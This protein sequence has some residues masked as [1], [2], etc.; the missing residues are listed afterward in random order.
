MVSQRKRKR[1]DT[2]KAKKKQTKKTKKQAPHKKKQVSRKKK[3]ASRKKTSNKVVESAAA[4]EANPE[5][6]SQVKKLILLLGFSCR[7]LEGVGFP[8]DF[9][10]CTS[11]ELRVK[12]LQ[13]M[14]H[15]DT[16]A[17]TINKKDNYP[18]N[19]YHFAANFNTPRFVDRLKTKL[20]QQFP[21]GVE[22]TDV[23]L[24]YY[25]LRPSWYRES[26]GT[27]WPTVLSALPFTGKAYLPVS[28]LQPEE[29]YSGVIRASPGRLITELDTVPLCKAAKN[30]SDLQGSHN[31][32]V[33][34]IA[35]YMSFT[36]EQAKE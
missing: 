21:A 1:K 27:Q 6:E 3:R 5:A 23:Y 25:N 14:T 36:P 17:M 10:S 19:P 35:G 18:D 9:D 33:K 11:D 31:H 2:S 16:R 7:N 28:N 24:D 15:R 8:T 4:A 26:Y 13:L 22:I 29:S 30:I 32:H 12:S 20:K 34:N